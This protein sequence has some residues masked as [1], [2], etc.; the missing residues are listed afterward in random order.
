M[1]ITGTIMSLETPGVVT[2]GLACEFP[3]T[4]QP[5]ATLEVPAVA[6][7]AALNPEAP[8]RNDLD[9]RFVPLHD[10]T[11]DDARRALALLDAFLRHYIPER[12]ALDRLVQ[13]AER[14]GVAATDRVFSQP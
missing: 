10:A 13:M 1:S 9:T 3:S 7:A 8:E 5:P 12:A 14:R 11:V 6:P 4:T 2:Y